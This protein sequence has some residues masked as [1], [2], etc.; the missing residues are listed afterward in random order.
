MM[1]SLVGFSLILASQVVWSQNDPA[2]NARYQVVFVADWS[3]NTQPVGFPGNPHF[4]GL[5]GATHGADIHLWEMG[6]LATPGIKLMAETGS[7]STFK[8]LSLFKELFL[9]QIFRWA[10]ILK[11]AGRTKKKLQHD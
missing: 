8:P 10:S 3:V 7:K 6:D 1:K 11:R 5:I 2:F 9:S 4:S